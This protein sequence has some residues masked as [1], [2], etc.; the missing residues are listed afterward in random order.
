MLS[1]NRIP[2][3]R[4]R[5]GSDQFYVKVVRESPFDII[6]CIVQDRGVSV[7]KDSAGVSLC[8]DVSLAYTG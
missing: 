4:S 2:Y 3:D 7:L 1:S 5:R 6:G 8:T